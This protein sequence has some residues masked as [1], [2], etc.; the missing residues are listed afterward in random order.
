MLYMK[1]VKRII[2]TGKKK[3]TPRN[4]GLPPRDRLTDGGDRSVIGRGLKGSRQS[5]RQGETQAHRPLASLQKQVDGSNLWEHRGG[6]RSRKRA[7]SPQGS[8][9]PAAPAHR[10]WQSCSGTKVPCGSLT[11]RSGQGL[12]CWNA[13]RTGAYTLLG[14]KPA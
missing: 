14:S 3:N 9:W 7:A 11:G 4:R 8:P 12:S 10:H 5:P 1:V 2:A 13:S 6:R